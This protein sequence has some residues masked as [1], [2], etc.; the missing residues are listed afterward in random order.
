M[1]SKIRASVVVTALAVILGVGSAG[2]VQFYTVTDSILEPAG[3]RYY[4][5]S[6]QDVATDSNLAKSPDPIV[7]EVRALAGT[8]SQLACTLGVAPG[9]GLGW[10]FTFVKNGSLTNL[11]CSVSNTITGHTC[12]NSNLVDAATVAN[13]DDVAFAISPVGGVP[14]AT[15]ARCVV[16]FTPQ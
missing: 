8:V 4:P 6:I 10:I 13:G 11:A 14:A 1:H 15:N 12:Q 2:A 9:V 16:V 7:V 5:L 3:T